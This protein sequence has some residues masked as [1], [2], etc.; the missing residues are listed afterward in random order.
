MKTLLKPLIK[1]AL[2]LYLLSV[3]YATA[4]SSHAYAVDLLK[5][6]GNINGLKLAYQYHAPSLQKLIGDSRFYFET[7]VNMWQYDHTGESESNT[8][9]AMSPVIQYP[10]FNFSNT[11]VYL[12]AGIGI[13]LIKNTYF[14]GKD[15]STHYQFE[16]RI[17][18]VA[19]FEQ[20]DVAL[21]VIHYSNAGLKEPNPGLN[22]LTLSVAKY[23]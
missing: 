2:F 20:V 16:D 8:L 10:A 21:R 19:S 4:N 17:G 5:G 23:F 3:N 13:S 22:F 15:I 12:E 11:P 1:T 18:L 7:S 14:A 9:L 6:E